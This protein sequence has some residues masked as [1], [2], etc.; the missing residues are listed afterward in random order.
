MNK[1][2]HHSFNKESR[3]PRPVTWCFVELPYL[4]VLR[5]VMVQDDLVAVRDSLTL[6]NTHLTLRGIHTTHGH[7]IQELAYEK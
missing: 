4:A 7:F 3:V 5:V 6:M 2:T 1:A